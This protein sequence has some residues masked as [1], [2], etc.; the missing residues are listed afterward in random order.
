MRKR[1]E[2]KLTNNVFNHLQ[3]EKYFTAL[4]YRVETIRFIG[5][6][7][8]SAGCWQVGIEQPDEEQMSMDILGGKFSNLEERVRQWKKRI[9]DI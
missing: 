2:I 7:V 8:I 9:L 3:I 1:V 5:E 4:G 6:E